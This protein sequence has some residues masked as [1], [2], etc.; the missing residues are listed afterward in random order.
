MRLQLFMS[1]GAAS[2]EVN[3][4]L[5]EKLNECLSNTDMIDVFGSWDEQVHTTISKANKKRIPVILS[6]LS[7]LQPWNMRKTP[8]DFCEERHAVKCSTAIHVTSRMELETLKNLKWNKNVFL[9]RNSIITKEIS[10]IEMAKDLLAKYVQTIENHDKKVKEKIRHKVEDTGCK[11]SPMIQIISKL[12][13]I[14]YLYNRGNLQEEE[15][16]ALSDLLTGLDYDEDKFGDMLNNMKISYFSSCLFQVTGEISKL[17]E[18]FMPIPPT[19]DKLTKQIRSI[20][21]N[22]QD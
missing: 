7:G 18:G 12:L 21:T 16:R 9:I 22:Y 1:K 14:K 10:D 8:V 19:E 11:D 13:Y 4:K 20:I 3:G 2:S 17:T 15:I 6:P 5:L